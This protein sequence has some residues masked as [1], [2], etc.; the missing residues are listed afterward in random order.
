MRL[1]ISLTLISSFLCTPA[2]ADG[3]RAKDIIGI[4][5]G[6]TVE[7][8]QAKI[9]A[10]NP[11]MNTERVNTEATPELHSYTVLLQGMVASDKAGEPPQDQVSVRF[12]RH[13]D[14]SVRASAVSHLVYPLP[15]NQRVLFKTF[16][17]KLI[18]KYGPISNMNE[19]GANQAR[20][21]FGDDGS[22]KLRSLSS[23]LPD[24]DHC[25]GVIPYI[26]NTATQAGL[27]E[28]AMQ[29]C[30]DFLYVKM[31]PLDSAHP[32]VLAG[33]YM[34]YINQ[35]QYLRDLKGETQAGKD[36]R[37]MLDYQKQH[38]QGKTLEKNAGPKF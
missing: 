15:E 31:I 22:Q 2:H 17:E 8:A 12:T 6:M 20:W 3:L 23:D 29:N 35:E 13:T 16:V 33:Y 18:Q 10:Y 9:N 1:F 34:L 27:P 21:V 4:T 26:P 11:A 5:P 7:E 14:G 28:Y 24:Y 37:E 30:G 19:V 25:S 38:E 32:D 36:A